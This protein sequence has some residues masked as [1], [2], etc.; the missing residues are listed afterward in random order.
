MS[1]IS[2]LPLAEARPL[3]CNHSFLKEGTDKKH[4]LSLCGY[5]TLHADGILVSR[6]IKLAKP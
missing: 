1:G 5:F 3:R 6:H 2:L 4:A